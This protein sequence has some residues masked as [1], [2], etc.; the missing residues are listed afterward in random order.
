LVN[1]VTKLPAGIGAR[2]HAWLAAAAIEKM[3]YDA[4][5]AL[6]TDLRRAL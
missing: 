3:S 2:A 5:A 1:R 4:T 6:K